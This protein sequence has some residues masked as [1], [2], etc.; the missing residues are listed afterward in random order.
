MYPMGEERAMIHE[1]LGIWLNPDQL[2][3]RCK[4][5]SFKWRNF[6]KSKKCC[7]RWQTSNR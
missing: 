2:P 1:I 7:G 6:G 4:M 5:C 3:L